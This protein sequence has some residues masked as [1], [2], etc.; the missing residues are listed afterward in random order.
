MTYQKPGYYEIPS[1][2]LLPL[3]ASQ[4]RGLGRWE[5]DLALTLSSLGNNQRRVM[6]LGVEA[7]LAITGVGQFAAGMP[8]YSPLIKLLLRF[9]YSIGAIDQYPAVVGY[10]TDPALTLEE[11]LDR[12]LSKFVAW[13]SLSD[14][15]GGDKFT[16]QS[17]KD[18]FPYWLREIGYQAEIRSTW[19][20]RLRRK[21]GAIAYRLSLGQ[22]VDQAELSF[23]VAYQE[24]A[25]REGWTAGE[26]ATAGART[27][28]RAIAVAECADP[29]VEQT[30]QLYRESTEAGPFT[31]FITMRSN[32]SLE[33]LVYWAGPAQ[34]TLG[35]GLGATFRFGNFYEPRVETV[36]SLPWSSDDQL[37]AARE[38][39]LSFTLGGDKETLAMRSPVQVTMDN[40]RAPKPRFDLREVKIRVNPNGE[41]IQASEFSYF[42]KWRDRT[43]STRHGATQ[44]TLL[45][46]LALMHETLGEGLCDKMSLADFPLIDLEESLQYLG[47]MAPNKESFVYDILRPVFDAKEGIRSLEAV[48]VP[49]AP[50][51]EKYGT[52]MFK[53]AFREYVMAPMNW[54]FVENEEAERYIAQYLGF[55]KTQRADA[56]RVIRIS[57]NHARL[58]TLLSGPQ[59]PLTDA[60]VGS[61]CRSLMGL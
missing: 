55:N 31:R 41:D 19:A 42:S 44:D 39:A 35:Y 51:F 25:A 23:Y 3:W 10:K 27:E 6:E 48:K 20:D 1:G 37:M 60:K 53:P 29:L 36:F 56:Q 45:E 28:R 47:G 50:L 4:V 5:P 30:W 43:V 34:M 22:P 15:P 33:A 58:K 11:A 32:R 13:P 16:I 12:M 54:L 46:E 57:H 18:A 9:L 49:M 14:L 8:G 40:A 38:R 61:L 59:L 21:L 7:V 26:L 52:T 2:R 24:P 17:L